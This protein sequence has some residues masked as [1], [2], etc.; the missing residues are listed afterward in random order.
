MK[1][2]VPSAF[3]TDGAADGHHPP[4]FPPN[5]LPDSIVEHDVEDQQVRFTVDGSGTTAR[6][7]G[8]PVSIPPRIAMIRN[9]EQLRLM[10]DAHDLVPMASAGIEF[11][12][13]PWQAPGATDGPERLAACA[14][15]GCGA[16]GCATVGC[17]AAGGGGGGCA[18]AGCAGVGCA[19]AGC[20]AVGCAA[21]ACA[22]AGKGGGGC[23]AAG[24][25]AVGCGAAGCAAAACG[26]VLCAAAGCATVACGAATGACGAAACAL[27]SLC[28]ANAGWP[29]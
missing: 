2:L 8:V 22:A 18:A 21:V 9:S 1:I 6:R 20:A 25:G 17:A 29:P 16:V 10:L 7:F 24:C 23:A 11:D 27:D 28:G 26:A 15:A 5:A 3:R 4:M 14:A 12:I 13:R 19:A